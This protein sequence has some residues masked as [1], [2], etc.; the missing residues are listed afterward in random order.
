MPELP[1][2][3]TTR[4]GIEPHLLGQT[5][6]R[7]LI[8]ESRLRWRVPSRLALRVLEAE[9]E[10]VRRRAKYLLIDLAQGS[11]IVHLGMSGSLRVLPQTYPRQKHDHIDLELSS[12]QTLRFNDPRRFGSWLWQHRGQTHEL[13]AHLGPEPLSDEFD[14]DY[15]WRVSRTRRAPVKNFIMDQNIVVGVGNIYA[16][17]ALFAAGI[18][19]AIEAGKVSRA[20]YQVLVDEIR[21][22]LL[23]AIQCG[24]TTL[25]DFVNPDGAPGYFAQT[26]FVYGREGE[27]CKSCA[28]TIRAA[29]WGQRQTCYCPRCQT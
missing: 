17:E 12:N 14:G 6:T 4:R 21:R 18:R 27:A 10:A 13:L 16:A 25:R 9:I 3:E 20:R 28:H 7:L 1:E 11:L 24:G 23:E 29:T 8:H 22:I 5:I 2:V 26:L 19:P 15:L